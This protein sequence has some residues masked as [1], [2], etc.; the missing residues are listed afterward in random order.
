MIHD[1]SC[2]ISCSMKKDESR[3]F[4]ICNMC[5]VYVCGNEKKSNCFKDIHKF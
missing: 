5:K 1:E 3:P 4:S 2:M